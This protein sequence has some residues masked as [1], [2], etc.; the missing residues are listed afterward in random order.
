MGL[1]PASYYDADYYELGTRTG[2]SCYDD[3][4]WLPETTVR[5]AAALVDLAGVG[6][7]EPIL[8]FGC[9]RGYLVK[10]LRWLHRDAYGCDH[11][12]WA[13]AHGDDAIRTYL[14]TTTETAPLGFTAMDFR[15][16]IAKD[17]L[18]HCDAEGVARQLALF[19]AR[20]AALVVVVPL[21][22][23]GRYVIPYMDE[24]PDHVLR[25][26]LSWW[27]EQIEV[28]GF[29]VKAAHHR[30]VGIKDQ[31]AM[32]PEGHLVVYAR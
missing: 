9:A 8:D 32:Y 27:V 10:A 5:L 26:P 20:S 7:A 15:L 24:E 22:S 18:E 17:V 13:I 1:K 3:Y 6:P 30:V 28:A 31:W 25:E 23:R 16:V 2:R 14:R 11:S 4:R 21:G 12:A 19:R 29:I